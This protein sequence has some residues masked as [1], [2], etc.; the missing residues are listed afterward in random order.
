MTQEEKE[1]LIKD[2]SGRIPYRHN[3]WLLVREFDEDAPSN[4]RMLAKYIDDI[5]TGWVVECKP[6]L[7]PMTS[8]T[9]EEE[10]VFGSFIFTEHHGWDGKTDYHEYVCIDNI[11]KFYDWLNKKM[12]DYRGLIPRGLALEAK[13][14]MYDLELLHYSLPLQ[15][16]SDSE[17]DSSTKITVGCKIRSKTSPYEILS[18]ISNDCH[19]DE[20][21]CS[22]GSVLSLKQIKKHYDLYIEENKGTIVIN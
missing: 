11:N 9:E 4:R 2:L 8:M 7:R 3:V 16:E 14:G 5:Y 22:N 10:K 19:G 6:Y 18:I 12:F 21:E 13:E 1:L 20:F 15:N 17:I